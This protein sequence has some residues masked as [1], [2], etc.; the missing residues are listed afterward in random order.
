MP[1]PDFYEKES[2]KHGYKHFGKGEMTALDTYTCS[3][4]GAS[5]RDRLYAHDDYVE[6]LEVNEFVVDQLDIEYFGEKLFKQLGLK[7]TSILYIVRKP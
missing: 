2:K 3:E 7:K 6:K 1:L 5:D 4:C